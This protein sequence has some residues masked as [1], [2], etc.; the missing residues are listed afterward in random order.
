MLAMPIF[1]LDLDGPIY[2]SG[3]AMLIALFLLAIARS[4]RAESLIP[5]S[6]QGLRLIR[7]P[8]PNFHTIRIPR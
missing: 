2:F 8:V 6:F 3:L 7:Q 1:P 5:S 4:T